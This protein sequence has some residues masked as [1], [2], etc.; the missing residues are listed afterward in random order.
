MVMML[1]KYFSNT[2]RAALMAGVLIAAVLICVMLV[3]GLTWL[4]TREKDTPAPAT[5]P[6]R[7]SYCG[8]DLTALCVVSF[9]RNVFGDT[10]INLYVPMQKYPAF[11][12]NI[13]RQSGE[14]R[15]ECEWETK[16]RTNVHCTGEAINLGEGFQMQF[17]S[18]KDSVMIARGDFTLTAYLVTTQTA[19]GELNVSDTPAPV[20]TE[21]T[22]PTPTET[23]EETPPAP[24]ETQ[25]METSTEEATDTL[26][27]TET[28]TP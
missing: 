13:I 12:L 22:S 11:Y 18:I 4:A 10:V 28:A 5:E 3:V 26:K 24:A 6:I 14:S 27:V 15:F 20:S 23:P 17:L 9:S 19:D 25:T 21:K 2:K 7:I 16:V 8:A 1:E